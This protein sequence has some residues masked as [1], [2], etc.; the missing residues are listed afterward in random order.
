MP[1][2]K[3]TPGLSLPRAA[4]KRRSYEE[5]T[6]MTSRAARIHFKAVNDK[7]EFTE[8]DDGHRIR[9]WKTE[10]MSSYSHQDIADALRGRNVVE[11]EDLLE[12]IPP[13]AI[14][15]AVTK[16]WLVPESGWFRVTDKAVF[17]L[18]LPRVIRGRKIRFTKAVR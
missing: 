9:L 11:R 6:G 8:D 7:P 17:E 3:C 14:K 12:V 13:S 15:Y 10:E 4:Q 16:Q 5:R 1:K 18:R 2:T